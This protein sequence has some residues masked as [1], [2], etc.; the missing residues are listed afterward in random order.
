MSTSNLDKKYEL[1]FLNSY[2]YKRP[3]NNILEYINEN[4]VFSYA[5]NKIKRERVG[6]E[7]SRELR[8]EEEKNIDSIYKSIVENNI[9]NIKLLL[10]KDDKIN[11]NRTTV[12]FFIHF[13]LLLFYF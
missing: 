5:N 6:I 13:I 3:S 8:E 9:E 12:S 10:K 4:R 1:N 11:L 7:L 2:P